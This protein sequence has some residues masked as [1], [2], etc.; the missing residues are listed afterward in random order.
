[1]LS[2]SDCHLGRGVGGEGCQRPALGLEARSRRGRKAACQRQ[3]SVGDGAQV[4]GAPI[5]PVD[6]AAVDSNAEPL[7]TFSSATLDEILSR[8]PS[9]GQ[10]RG[11]CPEVH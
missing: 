9:T 3:G 1:M 5:D 8:T 7:A 11:H 4:K 6:G 10:E 2:S